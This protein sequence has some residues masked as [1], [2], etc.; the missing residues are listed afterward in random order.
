MVETQVLKVSMRL[1]LLETLLKQKV[2]WRT[3]RDLKR[4]SKKVGCGR[5]VQFPFY[6]S[7]QIYLGCFILAFTPMSCAKFDSDVFLLT[8]ASIL[9]LRGSRCGLPLES[10]HSGSCEAQCYRA[11]P[12]AKNVERLPCRRSRHPSNG[13]S[14]QKE[15]NQ[16][17]L[18]RSQRTD[19][20]EPPYMNS[21]PDF[22][23]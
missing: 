16:R 1:F 11:G 3:F 6:S 14:T 9:L 22:S 5:T 18:T 15:N 2:L 4:R 13:Q 7:M 19:S 8:K 10:G 20:E 12:P 17:F 21:H 23:G